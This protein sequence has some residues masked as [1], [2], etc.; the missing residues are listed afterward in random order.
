M[1]K[2]SFV[3]AAAVLLAPLVAKPAAVEAAEPKPVAVVS[4]AGYDALLSDVE[5]VGDMVGAPELKQSIEGLIGIFTQ[6]KGLAGLAKDKPIGAAVLLSEEGQPSGFV[7][8][9]VSDLDKLLEVFQ[10]T[11]IT[12]TEELD[13]DF[14][15]LEFKGGKEVIAKKS[16]DWAFVSMKK[17]FLSDLPADPSKLLGDLPKSYD[18]AVKVIVAN[19]PEPLMDMAISQMRMG[20]EQAMQKAAEENPEAAEVQKALTEGYLEMMTEAIKDLDSY[21]VGF[22]IDDKTRSAYLDVTALMKDGSKLAEQV[23]KS[24]AEGKPSKLPGLADALRIFNFHINAPVMEDEIEAVLDLIEQ[25]RETVATKIKEEIADAEGQKVVTDLVNDV[26]DVVEATIEDGQI[27]GGAV[28]TGDGPFSVVL[29]AK[30]VDGETIDDV[31]KRAAKLAENEA[32]FPEI[33]FD[34]EEKAG[35]TFHIVTLPPFPEDDK[36]GFEEFFGSEEASLAIGISDEVLMLSIGAD[37]VAAAVEVLGKK[38]G[39]KNLPLMQAQLK[40][41]PL[42]KIAAKQVGEEQPMVAALAE[43]ML[44][45]KKDHL[46]LTATLIK[47][48]ERVRFEI[49]EGIISSIG[50]VGMMAAKKGGR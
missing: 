13:D 19:V 24:A 6:F 43:E 40:V 36:E 30:V 28:I 38:S 12:K 4:L 33:E 2:F 26:F 44:K 25:G 35:L 21:T 32:D 14:I 17:E 49:E 37:P 45:S 27:N 41:G 22:A 20:A 23:S 8:L 48:G 15:S 7:F 39:A 11:V 10:D 16:G 42:M 50:K 9:P 31:L 47:N 18:A 3:L 34:A 29:G 1:N 46:N 5:L